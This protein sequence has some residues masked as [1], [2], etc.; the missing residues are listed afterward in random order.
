M[1]NNQKS[2]M[3]V[4]LGMSQGIQM[5]IFKNFRRTVFSKFAFFSHDVIGQKRVK[6]EKTYYQ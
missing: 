1:K 4:T 6:N 3:V 5:Q 2:E